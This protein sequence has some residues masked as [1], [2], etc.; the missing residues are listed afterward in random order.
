MDCEASR[1]YNGRASY[2][3]VWI[4]PLP[5]QDRITSVTNRTDIAFG[6]CRLLRFSNPTPWYSGQGIVILEAASNSRIQ[7]NVPCLRTIRLTIAQNRLSNLRNDNAIQWSN[8][9]TERS[10]PR[11]RKLQLK[12]NYY[13][14]ASTIDLRLGRLS[15]QMSISWIKVANVKCRI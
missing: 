2:S 7:C 14:A 8:R 10:K 15:P 5:A 9:I 1:P 6:V 12:R 11:C 3:E 13:T 4:H